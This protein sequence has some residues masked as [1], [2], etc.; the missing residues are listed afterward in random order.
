MLR[1]Y[2]AG[3]LRHIRTSEHCKN[4]SRDVDDFLVKRSETSTHLQTYLHTYIQVHVHDMY[5]SFTGVQ[6][7]NHYSCYFLEFTHLCGF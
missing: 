5:V 3:L 1:D 6:A 4:V 2:T 7:K